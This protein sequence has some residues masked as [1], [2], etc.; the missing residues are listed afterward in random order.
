[1]RFK[2][3]FLSLVQMITEFRHQILLAAN[4]VAGEKKSFHHQL[5]MLIKERL[6]LRKVCTLYI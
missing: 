6:Y 5:H 3:L 2:H 1:M 4:V